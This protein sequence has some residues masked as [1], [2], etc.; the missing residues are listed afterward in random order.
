VLSEGHSLEAETIQR[1][2]EILK[3]VNRKIGV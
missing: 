2:A 3:I 1:E